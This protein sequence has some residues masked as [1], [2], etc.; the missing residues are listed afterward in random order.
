MHEG[1]R[2]V[3]IT[4]D[5]G[6]LSNRL[7]GLTRVLGCLGGELPYTTGQMMCKMDIGQGAL[8]LLGT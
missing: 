7:S 2:V 1:G 5:L 4:P 8:A 6:S 3:S